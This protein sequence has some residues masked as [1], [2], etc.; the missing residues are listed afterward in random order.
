MVKLLTDMFAKVLSASKSIVGSFAKN[1]GLVSDKFAKVS[2]KTPHQN[3]SK[4]VF[5]DAKADDG[6]P[7]HNSNKVS[8]NGSP[9]FQLQSG[10]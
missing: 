2:G 1:D 3:I 10:K 9:N 4:V 8:D 6:A 5:D 7:H